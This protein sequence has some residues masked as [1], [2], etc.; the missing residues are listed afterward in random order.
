MMKTCRMFGLDFLAVNGQ[1][2]TGLIAE[3]AEDKQRCL[4]ITPNVDHIVTVMQQ[5]E[6]QNIYRN[7]K[8]LFADGMPLVWLSRILPGSKLPAR[9][10]GAD[11]IESVSS[12]CAQRK[13][14]MA[15][16]GGKPGVAS[17]AAAVLERRY[18]GLRVVGTYSPPFGFEQDESESDKIVGL[19]HDWKPDIVCL[20]FGAPK[21]ELWASKYLAKLPPAPLL[22]FGAAIDFVAG[23]YQRAPLW[24]QKSGLEW[25]WRLSQDPVRMF[26]R[27]FLRDS[28][29]LIYAANEFFSQW[30]VFRENK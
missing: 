25:L 21:Q 11:L 18:P 7:T 13:L 4:V 14:T 8:L 15:L 22:C 10:T 17:S 5:P 19:C 12:A 2:A 23:E 24:M 1:E 16:I 9:V 3:A 28:M 29:F 6:I 20:A 30:R 27:Y 26:K